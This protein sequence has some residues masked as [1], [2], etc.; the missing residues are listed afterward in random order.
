MGHAPHKEGLAIRILGSPIHAPALLLLLRPPVQL[1]PRRRGGGGIILKKT[2]LA[3]LLCLVPALQAAEAE[4]YAW[5]DSWPR[6][7]ASEYAV[8]GLGLAG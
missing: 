4:K 7:R 8:T 1:H 6:F 2:C 3:L 5:D